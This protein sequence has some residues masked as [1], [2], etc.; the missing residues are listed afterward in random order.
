[1]SAY[2]QRAYGQQDPSRR[3]KGIAVVVVVHALIAYALVSGMARKGLDLIK[4][5]LEAVV[6]QEVIIPPPPPPPP[7]KPMEV[8][9][10]PPKTEATPPPFV[11]PPDVAPAVTNN[12]PTIVA[13]PVAPTVAPTITPPLPVAPTIAPPPPA[14][15]PPAPVAA[16]KSS[17][18]GVV[19]PSQVT[20][21]MPRKALQDG[22]EGVVK[23]QA[24]IKDGTV[25][26][27]TIISG[28]RVFHAAVRE[29]MLQYKCSQD[30]VEVVAVQEF[31][32]KIE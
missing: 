27:V 31:N 6:I 5:P 3:I 8:A 24:R 1:M 25:K 26:E 21:S 9:K 29:A 28:P 17:N 13:S 23:A 15:A 2:V 14:A 30:S 4:K 32:F 12:S 7:P 22:T 16:P 20:P 10:Q 18:I 19:C 11:P